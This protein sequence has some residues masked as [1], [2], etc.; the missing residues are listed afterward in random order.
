MAIIYLVPGTQLEEGGRKLI[1]NFVVKGGLSSGQKS[2]MFVQS[3]PVES[4]KNHLQIGSRST[5]STTGSRAW[6][7]IVGMGKCQCL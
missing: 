6:F 4:Q 3:S 2:F 5:T 1:E 7:T